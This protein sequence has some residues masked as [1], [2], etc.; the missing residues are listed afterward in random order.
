MP[1]VK[2]RVELLS[3]VVSMEGAGL[4][5]SVKHV[6]GFAEP[7]AHGSSSSRCHLNTS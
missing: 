7:S 2:Q 1:R 5:L 6:L 3:N 4:G